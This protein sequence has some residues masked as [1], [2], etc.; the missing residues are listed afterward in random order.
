MMKAPLNV[1][2]DFRALRRVLRQP[3]MIIVAAV[4]IISS[5]TLPPPALAQ[6]DA[7]PSY[8]IAVTINTARAMLD[9]QQSVTFTNGTGA[10]LSSIVLRLPPAEIAGV[11]LTRAT[12]TNQAGEATLSNAV[13]EIPVQP[14]I[15]PGDRGRV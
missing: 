8:Q 15:Q 6:A 7:R 11:S 3:A 9:V 12:A 14:P 1:P 4:L 2:V 13:L 5:W 10:P